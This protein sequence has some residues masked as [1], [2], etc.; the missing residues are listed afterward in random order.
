M[1]I[2][3]RVV[4]ATTDLRPMVAAHRSAAAPVAGPRA[5]PAS[6]VLELSTGD[7]LYIPRLVAH[8]FLA[9]G[10]MA[11]VYL[12][13]HEYDGTDELGFT[14]DDPDAAIPWPRRTP[15]VSDRDASSPSLKEA[16]ATLAA[17]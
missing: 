14:W 8:G 1:V 9:L 5:A 17:D 6:Q 16:V 12:V 2:E 4:A 15:I 7:A 11:L 3:G 10:E 13:S